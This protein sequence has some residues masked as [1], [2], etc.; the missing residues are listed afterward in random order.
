LDSSR[1]NTAPEKTQRPLRL[2]PLDSNGTPT[3]TKRTLSRYQDHVSTNDGKQQ[4][5]SL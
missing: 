3:S 5:C 1:P 4:I 2:K